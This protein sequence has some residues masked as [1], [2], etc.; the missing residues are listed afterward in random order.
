M[1]WPAIELSSFDAFASASVDE[2]DIFATQ[3]VEEE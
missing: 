2:Y 1:K 3:H